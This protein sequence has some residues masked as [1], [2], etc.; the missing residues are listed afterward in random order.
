M[1]FLVD[2]NCP[3]KVVKEACTLDEKS[4]VTGKAYKKNIIKNVNLIKGNI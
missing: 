3:G 2:K 1:G 4:K